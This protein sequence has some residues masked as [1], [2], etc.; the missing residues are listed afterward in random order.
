M[1]LFLS[2]VLFVTYFFASGQN[3]SYKQKVFA[4]VVK[5]ES[6]EP[7]HFIYI[8]MPKDSLPIWDS[9]ILNNKKYIVHFS[10][11]ETFPI[12]IGKR[13]SDG[14]M[15]VLKTSPD[16][17]IW[18]TDF[19]PTSDKFSDKDVIAKVPVIFKGMFRGRKL[20]YKIITEVELEN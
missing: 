2:L 13:M 8:E 15:V 5:S 1:R 20:T 18:F 17:D 14:K 19:E 7:K 9:A 3:A 16:T 11:V 6:E 4:F 12:T 10:K